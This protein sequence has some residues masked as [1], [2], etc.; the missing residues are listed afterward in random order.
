[1]KYIAIEGCIGIGKTTVAKQLSKITEESD[2]LLED[3]ESHPFLV[4]FYQDPKYTFETEIIFLLIHY[5]QLLK[6]GANTTNLL[7]G[8][9]YIGKDD[10]YAD[11][12]LDNTDELR[13]FKDL[14]RHL[15]QKVVSPDLIICLSA[16]TDL[17]YSR[18]KKRNR[19]E[20]NN[21]SY[22]YIEKVNK[23]YED[24]FVKIRKKYKTV[25]IDMNCWDFVK[26]R[27]LIFRLNNQLNEVF[28]HWNL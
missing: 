2:I 24:F 18:I 23:G 12:N 11:L 25:N 13:I 16:S 15:S 20:E 21:I 7:I 17:I 1:M 22:E 14:Y 28:I 10:L 5:H 26:D 19:A 9:Y 6:R 3:F 4:D 8:D 27:D